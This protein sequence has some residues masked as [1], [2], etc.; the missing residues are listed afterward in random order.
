MS[1]E[2]ISPERFL[3]LTAVQFD[4]VLSG[5][6]RQLAHALAQQGHAVTFVELP[7]LKV[8]LQARRGAQPAVREV[9]GIRVI[10]LAPLPW[11]IRKRSSWSERRWTRYAIARLG[12]LVP[13]IDQ[14]VVVTSTPWWLPVHADLPAGRRVYDC[15][16][17]VAV[18]A[19]PGRETVFAEW[20]RQVLASSDLVTAISEPLRQALLSQCDTPVHLLPNGVCDDWIDTNVE[21]ATRDTLAPNDG[22]PLAG[23]LGA[24]FEW[25]DQDLLAAV[26]ARMPDVAFAVVGPTRRG[27][28][29]STLDR[30][31]N[32]YRHGTVAFEDVPAVLEAFDVCLIPFK[33]DL[34]SEQADPLKLYEYCALG[35]PVVSTVRFNPDR[36]DCPFTVAA[37]PEAFADAI[38]EAVESDS[39][40][41]RQERIEFARKHTWSQ[42]GRQ[43]VSILHEA[44]ASS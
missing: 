2:R 11:A 9:D 16:D 28:A 3:F 41:A 44:N 5:R 22:R 35:K 1:D 10:R 19:G 43:L 32:V 24:V 21:A 12:K 31:A 33:K 34:V 8:T 42:R 38:R 30:A 7:G 37:T 17:N 18:Q 29:T 15:L 4:S 27:V 25:V 20:E 6:T 36:L 13:A 39:D 14:H 26:A 40:P 23:F